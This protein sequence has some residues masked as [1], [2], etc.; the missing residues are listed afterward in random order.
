[1]F[2]IDMDRLK[3]WMDEKN[4]SL[5]FSVDCKNNF[6]VEF[7]HQFLRLGG[8]V[9]KGNFLEGCPG[10]GKTLNMA[11]ESFLDQV[12]GETIVFF[13]H[14]EVAKGKER[15]EV[16]IPSFYKRVPVKAMPPIPKNIN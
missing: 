5:T 7:S 10:R 16:I 15:Q 4:I 2:E 8:D 11:L 13:T 1:M 9:K 6:M 3:K 12:T 14:T